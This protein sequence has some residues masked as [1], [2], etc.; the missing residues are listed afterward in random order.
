MQIF[1]IISYTICIG[2]ANSAPGPI[3]PVLFRNQRVIPSF[4]RLGKAA[5][6]RSAVSGGG[7]GYFLPERG[8]VSS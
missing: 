5:N 3:P 6:P 4:F 2:K 8:W 1:N 7:I